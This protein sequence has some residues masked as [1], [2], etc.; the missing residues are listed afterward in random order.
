[1]ALA[2]KAAVR[3][4]AGACEGGRCCFG[5]HCLKLGVAFASL[6]LLCAALAAA[7]PRAYI[8]LGGVMSHGMLYINTATASSAD[9][10]AAAAKMDLSLPTLLVGTLAW[11]LAGYLLS[12]LICYAHK[13]CC[14][15]K[16]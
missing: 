2:H 3:E 15:G 16:K 8:Y 11:L 1:M 7:V 13:G 14:G 9:Y 4:N 6:Y 5:L 10:A 12:C